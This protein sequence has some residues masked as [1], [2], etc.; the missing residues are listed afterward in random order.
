M[1][2]AKLFF[3]IPVSLLTLNYKVL[4]IMGDRPVANYAASPFGRIAMSDHLNAFGKLIN[5]L[6]N[7]LLPSKTKTRLTDTL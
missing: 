5:G 2:L 1:K 6:R 3:E 7:T 4:S